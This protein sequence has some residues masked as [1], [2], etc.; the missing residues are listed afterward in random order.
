LSYEQA[1]GYRRDHPVSLPKRREVIL[2]KKATTFREWP[3]LME[4]VPGGV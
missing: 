3:L 1:S 2:G 4:P